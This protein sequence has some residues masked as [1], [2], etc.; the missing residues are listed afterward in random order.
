MER[1]ALIEAINEFAD[2]NKI[3]R[4]FFAV[5]GNAASLLLDPSKVVSNNTVDIAFS[6]GFSG[7]IKTTHINGYSFNCYVDQA[8]WSS[9]K[10]IPESTAFVVSTRGCRRI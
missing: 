5:A 3:S 10:E 4:V 7:D 9:Y 8:A 2:K 6:M 1:V